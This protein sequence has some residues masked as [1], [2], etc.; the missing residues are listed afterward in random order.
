MKYKLNVKP[1]NAVVGTEEKIDFQG[2]DIEVEASVEEVISAH[3]VLKEVIV[4][5]SKIF[6]ELN[7]RTTNTCKCN[8]EEEIKRDI[9]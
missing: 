8:I 1:F 5:F 7:A 9:K 3:G 2:M 6:A 4:E